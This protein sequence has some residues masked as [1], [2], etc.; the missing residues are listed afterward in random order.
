MSRTWLGIFPRSGRR[1]LAALGIFLLS[2]LSPIFSEN[3]SPSAWRIEF[4]ER[5][6]YVTWDNV[7]T[8]DRDAEAG[9]AALSFRTKLGIHWEPSRRLEIGL[10]LANE[11]HHVLV[12][13]GSKFELNEFFMDS[14]YVLWRIGEERKF[15]LTLGRQDM[16]WGRGL[17]VAEGTPLDETRS[18]YFNA[19]RFDVGLGFNQ[20]LTG[21]ICYQPEKD[22]LLPVVNNLGRPLV[23]QPE[24]GLGLRYSWSGSGKEAEASLIYKK[25]GPS[26]G[27]PALSF[28]T[29]DGRGAFRPLPGL[30]LEGE[31]AIQLG[32]R[33][34]TGMTAWGLNIESRW[35]ADQAWPLLRQAAAGLVFL[36]GDNPESNG[37]EGWVPVFSRWPAW[38]ES[39]IF[40]LAAENNG[41]LAEWTNFASLFARL[42]LELTKRL[43]LSLG[44]HRLLAPQSS[45]GTWSLAR[46]EGRLRGNLWVFRLGFMFSGHLAGHL[47]YEG[48]NPGDY[49]LGGADG[50]SFLRFELQLLI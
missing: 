9:R 37:W 43:D 34:G 19:L 29:L 30:S 11:V 33:G 18:A 4:S 22:T 2:A 5:F 6:R 49:Y 1:R 41:R 7:Q 16:L 3:H 38:S 26:A 50:Y 36:S 32:K 42:E 10:R 47:L 40:T 28:L 23:E 45:S 14:L 31:G 39:Y 13:S 21:F 35:E 17:L 46:G 15:D 48:F 25:A 20:L 24:T 12:P 44:F 8:L 27:W